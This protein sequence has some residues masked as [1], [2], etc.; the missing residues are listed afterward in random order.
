VQRFLAVNAQVPEVAAITQRGRDVHR[1][2]VERFFA[3]LLEDV[4]PRQRHRRVATFVAISDLLTWKV[5]RL[6]QGLTCREY[7]DTVRK[8]LEAVS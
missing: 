2:W 7:V 5:L 4:D 3:A 6:E 8:P 1:A